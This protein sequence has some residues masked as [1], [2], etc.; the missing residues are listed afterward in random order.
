M[1]Q[2]F[3]DAFKLRQKLNCS[4]AITTNGKVK[5]NGECVMGRGIALQIKQKIPTFPGILGR[6]ITQ[7]GNHVYRFPFKSKSTSALY[8]FP[9]KHSWEQP[10]DIELIK[11]SAK[12]LMD[13]LGPDEIVILPRPGC[14]NGRLK[15]QNVE[16]VISPLLDDRVYIVHWKEEI[17]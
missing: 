3:G 13:A 1:K 12:E 7:G 2:V 5:A 9:V 15:W 14:G 11:R 16:P 17:K 10:A 8:S 6:K 4:L